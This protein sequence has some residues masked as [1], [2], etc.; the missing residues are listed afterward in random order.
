MVTIAQELNDLLNRL[1]PQR[2]KYLENL[3]RDALALAEG[4]ANGQPTWP[5]GYFEETAGAFAGEPFERAP[6]GAVPD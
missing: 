6:Q 4:T 1:D 5:A 3:V 2:A